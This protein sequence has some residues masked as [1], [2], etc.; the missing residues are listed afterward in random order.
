[1]SFPLPTPTSLLDD[2]IAYVGFDPVSAE[3]QSKQ[4]PKPKAKSRPKP[5]P[6]ASAT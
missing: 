5:T 3:A 2:Y 4:A 1:L 6:A